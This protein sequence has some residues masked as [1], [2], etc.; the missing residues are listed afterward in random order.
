MTVGIF[1]YDCGRFVL[2]W[3]FIY[4]CGHLYLTVGI[5]IYDCGHFVLMWAFIY[6]TVGVFYYYGHLGGLRSSL[7]DHSCYSQP[8][9]W[10]PG[11]TSHQCTFK[12]PL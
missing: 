1:I 12:P 10:I 3:A 6:I 9:Q 5:F 7:L 11:T 2:M 8:S 4:D